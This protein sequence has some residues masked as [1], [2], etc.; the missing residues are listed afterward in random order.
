MRAQVR[1]A[2]QVQIQLANF[3]QDML[4]DAAI[5]RRGVA[6]VVA[7]AAARAEALVDRVLRL[8]NFAQLSSYVLSG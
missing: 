7:A 8:S 6:N 4:K 5:Q 3:E 2:K 1:A